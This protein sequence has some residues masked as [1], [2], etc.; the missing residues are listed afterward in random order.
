M[1]KN[2][3]KYAKICKIWRFS[4]IAKKVPFQKKDEKKEEKK[5]EKK[6]DKKEENNEK[7]YD[8]QYLKYWLDNS[9]Q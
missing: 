8:C 2:M 1:Q 6:G 3:Q 9:I 5:E 7:K 4:N